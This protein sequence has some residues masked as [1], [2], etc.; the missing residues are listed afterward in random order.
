MNLDAEDRARLPASAA[1]QWQT[2]SPSLHTS[3]RCCPFLN[4]ASLLPI[5]SDGEP[6]DGKFLCSTLSKPQ[7]D[8]KD[9]P[10]PNP[11]L[12]LFTDGFCFLPK[13]LL[14]SAL[15]IRLPL[16]KLLWETH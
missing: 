8:L 10:L 3:L 2:G 14:S 11:D 6:H 12:V 7:Q 5:P 1:P 9:V 16:M 4:P 15:P 13:L